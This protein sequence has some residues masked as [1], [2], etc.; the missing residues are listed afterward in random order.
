MLHVEKNLNQLNETFNISGILLSRE[1]MWRHCTMIVGG[2][3]DCYA[4]PENEED[5]RRLITGARRIGVDWFV[6]GGGSNILP[7]DRGIRGLVIDMRRFTEE[8]ISGGTA[9][10]GAGLDI[11]Q[12]VWRLGARGLGGLDFIFGMPGSVGGAVWMNARCYGSEIADVLEWTDEMD[13]NGAVHRRPMRP[14]DWSSKHS[15]YQSSKSVILRA[16]FRLNREDPRHLRRTMIGHRNDREAKGH[17]RAPCAGS[18]F[19]N[20]RAFGAPSGVLMDR[21]GLK[22][23]SVGAAAVSEWHANIFVNRG[24]AKAAEFRELMNRAA[25]QVERTTGFRMEA[26]IL[27]V[28]D[29]EN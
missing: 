27:I 8:R 15:P 16:G 28:G 6:L 13:E 14:S 29:W 2:D 7:S 18:A 4:V 11:S 23:A 24:G 5:L 22:G 9:T 20:N 17:Y 1:P 19:K 21:C 3:A 26:E 12:A 25:L 10:L